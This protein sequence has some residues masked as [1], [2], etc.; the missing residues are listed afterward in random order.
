MLYKVKS[1]EDLKELY[2]EDEDGNILYKDSVYVKEIEN[3]LDDDR[4]VDLVE[5]NGKYKYE[6]DSTWPIKFEEWMVEKL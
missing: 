1:Y 6:L 5:S 3:I 4:I 2:G